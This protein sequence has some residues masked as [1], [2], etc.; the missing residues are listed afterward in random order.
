MFTHVVCVCL[1]E[2]LAVSEPGWFTPK[3]EVYARHAISTLGV[4]SRTT[5]YWPHTLQVSPGVLLQPREHVC[6]C[7][8]LCCLTYT[9]GA[10]QVCSRVDLADGVTDLPHFLLSSASRALDCLCVGNKGTC[11]TLTHS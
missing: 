9:V 6:D 5:G 10:D 7:A 2:Q 8:S 4:S 1:C 3:P 11:T